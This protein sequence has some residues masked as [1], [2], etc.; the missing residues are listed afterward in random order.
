MIVALDDVVISRQLNLD[1]K[2]ETFSMLNF[3]EQLLSNLPKPL[4]GYAANETCLQIWTQHLVSWIF[5]K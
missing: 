3:Q 5:E 4:N 1:H 2:I